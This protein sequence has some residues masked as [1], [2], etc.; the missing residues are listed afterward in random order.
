MEYSISYRVRPADLL[1]LT[2]SNIYTSV[3][4]FIN[5]VFTIAMTAL[6]F[7]FW[8]QTGP[9][10]RIFMVSGFLLFPI[11]QPVAIYL[12]SRKAVSVLPSDMVITFTNKGIR[13]S[14]EQENSFIQYSDLKVVK[15]R[16]HLL[17]LQIQSKGSYIINLR[18]IENHGDTIHTIIKD[19]IRRN[20]ETE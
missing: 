20:N 1:F 10:F 19:K 15:K 14:T 17:V 5:I 11:V 18:R 9:L 12:Q 16:L 6:I 3:A 7:K 2:L 4:G 8:L 13:L